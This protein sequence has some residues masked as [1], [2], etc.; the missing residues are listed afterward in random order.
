M[1]RFG[2]IFLKWVFLPGLFFTLGCFSMIWWA[3][4]VALEAAE[5][6][7][8]DEVADVPEMPVALVFG[9][10]KM[11]GGRHN[12]YF[13]NRIDAAVSLW[14]AGKVKSFIVSGD[15]SRDDYNEP[16][17]M[18]EAMVEAGVPEDRIVCDYAGLR[19]LDSVVRAKEIFGVE[20]VVLISQR[21][22]NERA[23]Y[24]AS[25]YDLEFVGLNA[26][27]V[28]GAAG[29]RADLREK[30]ARVKMWLD[31]NVLHTDPKY[32]GDKEDLPLIK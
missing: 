29:R 16:K 15:N 26:T 27:S 30:L 18:K 8:Y 11:I 21:F 6:K 12:L 10:A 23:A 2:L 31:V 28:G 5:G 3:N 22:H 4:R 25:R 24:L 17:D 7:L 20:K 19:T 13:L 1:R 9:C 32:F 14:E